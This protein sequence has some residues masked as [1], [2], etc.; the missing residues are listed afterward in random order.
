MHPQ[1]KNLRRRNTRRTTVCS[2]KLNKRP[3]VEPTRSPHALQKQSFIDEAWGCRR[4]PANSYSFWV[5]TLSPL[6]RNGPADV[7]HTST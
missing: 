6:T 5:G 1:R 4:C 2:T 7:P 3:L